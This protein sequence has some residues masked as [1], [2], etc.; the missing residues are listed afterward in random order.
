MGKKN[1]GALAFRGE[2]GLKFSNGNAGRGKNIKLPRG[3]GGEPSAVSGVFPQGGPGKGLGGGKPRR[4]LEEKIFPN[5]KK[6]K[7][8]PE[9]PRSLELRKKTKKR[10]RGAKNRSFR[11]KTKN[12]FFAGPH[13]FAKH[14]GRGCAGQIRG[15][16]K[17]KQNIRLQAK[18]RGAG[19]VGQG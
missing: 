17:K 19:D 2:A 6:K 18:R 1:R 11:Q 15:N 5:S 16:K 9:I 4:E 12:S 13:V 7:K 3:R 8:A 10:E 14:R